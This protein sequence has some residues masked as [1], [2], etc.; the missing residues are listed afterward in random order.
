VE[1]DVPD[2]AGGS[3]PIL[4]AGRLGRVLDHGQA[5]LSRDRHD[6][7][8][9]RRAAEDV[10]DDDRLGAGV[11][12]ERTESGSSPKVTSSMSANTGVAPCEGAGRRC[13][14][15]VGRDDDL[16]PGAHARRR[17]RG[18]E[19][20]VAEFI[21]TAWRAPK[22]SR[23]AA[24]IASTDGPPQKSSSH[25]PRNFDSTPESEN[26]RHRPALGLADPGGRGER[27]RAH[28]S[29]ADGGRRTA[30][31]GRRTAAGRRRSRAHGGHAGMSDMPPGR[32][33]VIDC[34]G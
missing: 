18:V 33:P 23:H 30:D 16:V 11:I 9:A 20:R 4:R 28:A 25:T 10:D 22:R 12:R 31:G 19:G 5:V 26:R 6:L 27:P 15:R 13:G 17:N 32:G 14:H 1:A 2:G 21:E 34:G 8:Q 29:A 24:S 3:A 7:V